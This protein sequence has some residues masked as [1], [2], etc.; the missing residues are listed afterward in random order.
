MIRGRRLEREKTKSNMQAE[1]IAVGTELLSGQQLDTNSS[2]LA[3]QLSNEGIEVS[4]KTCV[5]DSLDAIQEA[6]KAAVSRCQLIFLSGGLGPTADDL[7]REAIANFLGQRLKL[8]PR[9]LQ[10]IEKFFTS[11]GLEMAPSNQQQ[12]YF[13]PQA[14]ILENPAGTAPGFIIEGKNILIALPGVP[15]ELKLMFENSVLPY[16]RKKLGKKRNYIITKTIKL[17]GLPESEVATRLRDIFSE[18]ANPTLGVFAKPDEIQLCLTARTQTPKQGQKLNQKIARHIYQRLADYI[19]GED[20][21]KLEELVGR[22]LKKQ[23]LTLA[24]AES[25]TAGLLS[26]RLTQVAG[27]STYFLGGIV[28]YSNASKQS[29]LGVSPK[30]IAQYG[31]VSPECATAMAQGCLYRFK[32]QAAVALTGIAGPGGG[33]PEKPVGLV[34]QALAFKGKIKVLK[35]IFLGEREEIRQKAVKFALFSLLKTLKS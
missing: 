24:C 19:Y 9:V 21:E 15:R 30:L 18:Q 11:R 25:C 8:D 26:A 27:S 17:I 33:T 14:L 13:P 12:A 23:G 5:A 1:L 35:N 6:L 34:Y 4:F 3:Q 2:Y 22:E 31:A 10:S 16:L 32:A 29:L 20:E 28:S 7:T